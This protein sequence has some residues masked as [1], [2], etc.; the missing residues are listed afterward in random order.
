M[1]YDNLPGINVTLK[2]GGL[3][4]PDA[5]G[6]E[7]VLIIAPSLVKNAP[8]E[9]VRVRSS[10]ELVSYGFG[11]FYVGGEINPIAAEWKAAADAGAKV[12]YVV[13]LKEIAS[14][15]ASELEQAAINEFVANGGDLAS[16]QAKYQGV[17]T[18][19][20]EASSMR[21]K[22]V[23]YYDLLMGDLL[24]FTVD[25]IVLK[26]ATLED[27]V[28]DLDAAF[29]PEVQN[30]EDF[31][32]IGG[33]VSSSYILE[34]DNVEYP[35]QITT[36][37][38]DKLVLTVN[39]VDQTFTIPAKT[40]NGTDLTLADLVKDIQAVFDSSP[41]G[42]EVSV[43]QDNNKLVLYF[44]DQVTVSASTTA[45]ALK[46]AGQSVWKK[47]SLGLI[48]KGSFAQTIADYCSTKT[49]M[50]S[51][52]IGYIGVRSPVDSKVSTIRKYVN[53][54]LKIDTEISPYLQVVGSEVGVVMPVTN[55]IYYMNGATHY[56]ALIATLAKESAPTNKTVPGV[57]A[58]RFAYSLRQL[59]ALTAKK[60]VTFKL[61]D[62]TNL[63]VTDGVTTA[64]SLQIGSTTRD[65]DYA[66][67]STLRITQLAIQ[68]VREAV[69]P[70]IGEANGMPGYNAL[71][72][73]IK[74][75]LEKIREAGAIRGYRF[76]ITNITSRLDEANVVLEIVPAFELRRVE[77]QVN[78]IPSEDVLGTVSEEE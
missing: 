28:S 45:S 75:S 31:P 66:R 54:L 42:M 70:F 36:D 46:L 7:S 59:S 25:H 14:D 8:E 49:L 68:V 71:N 65:S 48:H 50:K 72:T 47:T 51:A 29:F 6:S 4:V 52:C 21:R 22:F 17:L 69:E 10:A 55:S 78:L 57:K 20:T 39:G 32:H 61:K 13:A 5:G 19:N 60:V 30:I 64:P 63:V 2:D 16:A 3:I 67:L 12:V 62:T 37:S 11:D 56:A 15:R 35:I 24:D 1:L 27:E 33:F 9:P 74:S 73:A 40:Y 76:S 58:I 34:S 41:T 26:G 23:Y 18:G 77:V 53:D 43:R 38:N 44:V